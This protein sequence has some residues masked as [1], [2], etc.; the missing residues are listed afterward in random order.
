M[1]IVARSFLPVPARPVARRTYG[2]LST[3]PPTPCGLATFSAALARGLEANGAHVGVVRVADGTRSSDPRVMA[4]MDNGVLS[5]VREATAALNG[6]GTVIAQHEYGLYGG[7]DG[8]EILDILRA[9]TVPAIVVAHTVLLDPSEHQRQVLEAICET[10]SAVVVMAETAR[11]RLCS[12]FDVDATKVTMIPH[13]ATLASPDYHPDP[14]GRPVLLTWGL[15]G[16]GKGVEWVIDAMADLRDL[17]PRPRYVVAGRT[18]PKVIATEGEAYREMLLARS[19]A[20]GVAP[21]VSFD[22]AY[23]DLPSL[24]RLVQDATV[25]VLP[26]DSQDQVTS[27]VLVD[28]LA[29]G[30]PVVATAFP[31]AVELLS[32]G[33]GIVVPHRD[34]TALGEALRHVLTGPGVA[35]SMAREAARLAPTFGW[36]AVAR[37]YTALAD[38]LFADSQAVPA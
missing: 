27:G 12:R 14:S 18:H 30:R 25:V 3:Y 16:R 19:W 4:E 32:S 6:C 1:N 34:A 38:N 17:R 31:H 21:S 10:A 36:P 24:T 23:R 5:S 26:Y 20:K 37:R 7:T 28:A 2:L 15:L 11:Q 22:S 8:D 35:T 9:L 33:A 29:A 13:G